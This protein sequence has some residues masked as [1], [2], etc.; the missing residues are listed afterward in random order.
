MYNE[1]VKTW[2]NGHANLSRRIAVKAL[3]DNNMKIEAIKMLMILY[4]VDTRDK[5]SLQMAKEICENKIF[6]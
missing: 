3:L 5:C 4:T 2:F 1:K 6:L